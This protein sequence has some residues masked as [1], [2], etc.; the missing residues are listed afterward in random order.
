[1]ECLQGLLQMLGKRKEYRLS[2]PGCRINFEFSREFEVCEVNLTSAQVQAVI[3][4]QRMRRTIRID[5][6]L[7]LDT[8]H[9]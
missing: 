3:S 6:Y 9:V 7:T 2:K 4:T 8:L 5:C 1:M